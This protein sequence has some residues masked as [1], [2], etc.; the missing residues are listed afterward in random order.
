MLFGTRASLLA[1]SGALYTPQ[2]VNFDGSTTWLS[3][4][5]T[6]GHSDTK[7]WTVSFWVRSTSTQ[8]DHIMANQNRGTEIDTIASGGRL[9]FQAEN[10]GG[11][12]IL[13]VE[14][15]STINDGDWHH[16]I[17]SVD[18]SDSGKRHL[19]IDGADE[20]PTW[21]TYNDVNIDHTGTGL[22]IGAETAAGVDKFTGDMADF[23][24]DHDTYLDL[25]DSAVLSKFY[26]RSRPANLLTDG[27]GPTG[28]APLVFLSGETASWHTNKGTGGGF[29]ENGTLTDASS[30]PP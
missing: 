5:G 8:N 10:T 11:S 24:F 28:A 6:V 7:K 13:D 12:T 16:V 26:S 23:W 29:T 14:S 17:L 4:G 3:G 18:L 22:N 30:N 27:S 1:A 19:Y 25:S 21:S 20:S 9:R 2:G 15:V